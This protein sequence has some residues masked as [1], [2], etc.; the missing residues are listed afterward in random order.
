VEYC[1]N[2]FD[3]A[4]VICSCTWVCAWRELEDHLTHSCHLVGSPSSTGVDDLVDTVDGCNLTPAGTERSEVKAQSP[5]L[6]SGRKSQQRFRLS[7]SL[8]DLSDMRECT[9]L[10]N[11]NFMYYT[12]C[13]LLLVLLC[14]IL[15][16]L[17]SLHTYCSPDLNKCYG[18]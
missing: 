16:L 11:D 15:E 17:H 12:V 13:M 10:W 6:R 8:N 3:S 5:L 14:S 1:K 9:V 18:C 4:A 7:S 2:L